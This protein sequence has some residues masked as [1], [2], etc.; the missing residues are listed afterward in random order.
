MRLA[1]LLYHDKEIIILDEATNALDKKSEKA[2]IQLIRSLRNKT[3]IISVMIMR[4]KF[5]DNYLK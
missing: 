1:R 4:S 5:C 2:V 3:I